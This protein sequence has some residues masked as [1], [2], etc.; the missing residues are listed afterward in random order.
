MEWYLYT[1]G[2]HATSWQDM[3][4]NATVWQAGIPSVIAVE[5]MLSREI[6]ETGALVPEQLS[7]EP[8]LRKLPEW[9][10]PLYKREVRSSAL[11]PV[12]R[13]LTQR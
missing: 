11:K 12:F 1:L 5:L 7:P 8:W 6:R 10:M 4:A 2:S 9:K 3:E 13:T